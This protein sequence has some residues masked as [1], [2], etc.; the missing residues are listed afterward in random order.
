MNFL[1]RIKQIINTILNRSNKIY[2]N[3]DT[4]NEALLKSKGYNDRKILDTV[5]LSLEKILSGEAK[6][7]RDSYLF[8]KKKYD[9]IL[10]SRLNEIYNNLQRK[11]IVCD[12]GGSLGS[13][14]FQHKEI[15]KKSFVEWNI[16]EQEHFVEFANQKIKIDNLNFFSNTDKLLNQKK[17]DLILFSSVLHYLEDPYS[18]LT[19]FLEREISNIFIIR[20]PFLK[21]TEE[22]KIQKVP[23]HIYNSSYP[24]RILNLEK[25][26]KLFNQFNYNLE[27]Q[28][29]NDERIGEYEYSNLYYRKKTSLK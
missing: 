29:K 19:K 22:I 2:G 21:N 26:Q 27:I 12:Y 18:V 16:L 5:K 9:N 17:L 6:Y 24:V 23:S 11:I 4:W 1:K 15:F 20:T 3:F 8:Y 14:Y 13:L 7:E 25:I 10:I 28:D